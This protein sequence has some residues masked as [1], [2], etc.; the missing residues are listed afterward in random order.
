MPAV[1]KQSASK[2]S[3]MES[4][5]VIPNTNRLNIHNRENINEL[6]IATRTVSVHFPKDKKVFIHSAADVYLY[7]SM[8]IHLRQNRTTEFFL[9]FLSGIKL[10][11]GPNE[12]SITYFEYGEALFYLDAENRIVKVWAPWFW[13]DFS[14]GFVGIGQIEPRPRIW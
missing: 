1:S 2:P 7:S 12:G 14:K 10:R 3:F 5:T 8:G 6:S 9:E 4:A 13:F 11:V